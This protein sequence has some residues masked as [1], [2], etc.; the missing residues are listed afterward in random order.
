[1]KQISGDVLTNADLLE[2][3]LDRPPTVPLP[4]EHSSGETW[5]SYVRELKRQDP[6][7]FRILSTLFHS[8]IRIPGLDHEETGARR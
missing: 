8:G 1:M 5:T 7:A 6:E 2:F 3:L 4:P